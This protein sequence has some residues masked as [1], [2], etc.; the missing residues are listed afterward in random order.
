MR[1]SRNYVRRGSTLALSSVTDSGRT[2]GTWHAGPE[3]H[4]RRP[5]TAALDYSLRKGLGHPYHLS[6]GD[7]VKRQEMPL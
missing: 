7:K 5:D 6:S 1:A 3:Y 2:E 4:E